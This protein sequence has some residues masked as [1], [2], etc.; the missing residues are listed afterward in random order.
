VGGALFVIG[1]VLVFALS[2]DLPFGSLSFPGAGFMPLIVASLL[3]LLGGL[4]AIGGGT[5]TPLSSI[6]WS[7]LPHAALVT[8]IATV[9]I[10][11]YDVLGFLIVM[12]AMMFALLVVIER[13]PIIPAG[14]YSLGISL[15]T[16]W[17]FSALRAPMPDSPFGF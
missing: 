3:I 9:A 4:L 7:D 1:G 5:S 16:W 15:V 13:K 12:P 6:D 11:L 8:V 10:A 14:L 17:L 2:G